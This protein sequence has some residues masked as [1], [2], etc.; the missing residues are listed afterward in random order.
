MRG[1]RVPYGVGRSV[2]YL[3]IIVGSQ[4]RDPTFFRYA[5]YLLVSIK[6]IATHKTHINA[7]A[8]IFATKTPAEIIKSA[9]I[10]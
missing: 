9:I 5:S 6:Y 2:L 4:E 1:A 3:Y 7:T 10:Q 8:A